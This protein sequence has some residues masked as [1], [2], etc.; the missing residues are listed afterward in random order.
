VANIFVAATATWNG[1]ALKKAKQ[2][3]NVF[4]K[5][6]KS[7]ARTLGFTFSAT[8]IV[9]FSKKAVKAF[10]EDEASAK[11]LQ[12]QLENTG[13]AFRVT[14]V[15]AYIKSLEKTFAI[16]TD[17][18]AP[19]KTLLNV[20]GSVDLA[21][22]SL[23]AALN[24]S[25]GTGV[26]LNTVVNAIAAGVRGQ[27]KAIKGLNTGIDES[28]LATGD[29]NK[30]MKELERRFAG[31]AAARLSTYSGKMDVLKKSSD[32]ATKAIGEGL[33]DALTILSKDQS[34]DNLANSFEN[35]GNNIAFTIT[36]MAKLI[37]KFNSFT[38]SPSFKPALLLAG[39]GISLA[40]G[41]AAPFLAAFGF[42]GASGLAGL[43]TKDFS[44]KPSSNFTYGA[45][46]PRADLLVS[47]NLVKARKQEFDVITKKNAIENKNVEELKKKFD[48]ERIGLTAALN[49]AT[50]D[51]TRIRLKAQLAIL[52]NNEALAKKLLAEMEATEALKKLAD[53]AN[54]AAEALSTHPDKYD[55][56][57]TTLINQFK[58]L[59]LT[60]QES[61]ALAAMSARYQAQADAID[62]G[63]SATSTPQNLPD[64]G[65]RY[66]PLSGLRATDRDIRITVDTAGSGDKFS[67]AIAESIQI[68]TRSGYSTV[69]AGFL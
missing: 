63:P 64:S 11:S 47:K 43:A 18:R 1:K 51:E 28:I 2:D 58:A 49:Q 22:R 31:Q 69:P 62:K 42:V 10:A 68:A 8:A 17:L 32:E 19:F 65:F 9:A 39:A 6:L 26:N 16:L 66:D 3:V 25:A 67:Q 56:M 45:G 29:M 14:E 20:T 54:K 52:D 50:D 38:S 12:L 35:L 36:Q 48:L 34:I 61:M 44:R 13:N 7:L 33:V 40:T 4:D 15:E 46:N 23:E 41:G 37:D 24:I 5:Q 30:I 21:Q 60:L 59:G 53:A 57:I 27:T 55:Q